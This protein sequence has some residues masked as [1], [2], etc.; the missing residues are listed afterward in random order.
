MWVPAYAAPNRILFRNK[1][2]LATVA[3]TIGFAAFTTRRF[4]DFL[5]SEAMVFNLPNAKTL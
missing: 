5:N 1:S 4:H 2:L 3:V